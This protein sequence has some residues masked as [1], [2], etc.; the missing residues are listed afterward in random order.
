MIAKE[1][2]QAVALERFAQANPQLLEEIAGLN[3]H[4]QQQQIQ[5][6]FDDQA[7]ERGLQSWELTL[8]LIAESPEQLREMRLE[9]HREVAEAL[10][11]S[12]QEYCEFNEIEDAAP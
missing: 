2:R 5:W 7:Q 12:W 1:S 9:V 6:A 4:E 11:L 3:A 8:E 10:G